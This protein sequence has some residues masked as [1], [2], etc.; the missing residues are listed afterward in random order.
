MKD[1]VALYAQHGE[2]GRRPEAVPSFSSG[3]PFGMPAGS[4]HPSEQTA[5]PGNILWEGPPNT[6]ARAQSAF[7]KGQRVNILGFAG[8]TVLAAAT[9]LSSCS[10]K[11]A[12]DDSKRMRAVS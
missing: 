11:A 6:Q 5:P 9:R 12:G 4:P 7:V 8:R 10:E 2:V 3:V 1:I